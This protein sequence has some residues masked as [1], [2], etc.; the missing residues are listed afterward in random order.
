MDRG[1][2]LATLIGM[3]G[4]ILTLLGL[5]FGVPSE[6]LESARKAVYK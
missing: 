4:K 2:P 3:A 6:V 5:F 1:H